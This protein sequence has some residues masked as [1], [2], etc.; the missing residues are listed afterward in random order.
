[1]EKRTMELRCKNGKETS[2]SILFCAFRILCLVNISIIE[3]K[4]KICLLYDWAITLL[5][6]FPREMNAYAHQ[7]TYTRIFIAFLLINKNWKQPKCLST[8]EW[9]YKLKYIYLMEYHI[10]LKKNKIYEITH[11]GHSVELKDF[12]QKDKYWMVLFISSWKTGNM[13]QWW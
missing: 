1:M 2:H 9:F 5:G 10:A 3:L 6:I 7:K 12:I 4:L 11:Q 8:R 13:N